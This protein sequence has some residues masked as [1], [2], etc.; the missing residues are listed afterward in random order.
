MRLS[1]FSHFFNLNF[2][3]VLRLDNAFDHGLIPIE[4]VVV[5]QTHKHVK[6]RLD[7]VFATGGVEVQF[8]DS[9]IYDNSIEMFTVLVVRYMLSL[10]DI[11]SNKSKI[12]ESYLEVVVVLLGDHDVFLL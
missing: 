10:L 9:C 5:E 11:F 3:V 1:V 6:Q 2:W 7:V 8:V 12:D 4:L